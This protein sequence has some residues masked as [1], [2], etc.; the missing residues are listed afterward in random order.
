MTKTMTKSAESKESKITKITVN[1]IDKAVGAYRALLEKN[2][3]E[4]G[5]EAMQSILGQPTRFANEILAAFH[6]CVKMNS[7][8][9]VL[10]VPVNRTLGAQETLDATGRHR[11]TNTYNE[12]TD[13][14]IINSMAKGEGKEVEVFFFDIGGRRDY[15]SHSYLE[16]EYEFR[17]LKPADPYSL[18]AVNKA[19]PKLADENSNFTYW[20]GVRGRL[21]S[22]DFTFNGIMSVGIFSRR[23]KMW[24]TNGWKK[25]CWFAGLRK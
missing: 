22:I 24:G 1:Q 14:E 20:K 18:A 25:K 11:Y 4:L 3:R 17:G 10:R 19:N 13:R 6:R 9:F 5:F 23:A 16:R 7:D 12:D 15:I 8:M 21:C 2:S